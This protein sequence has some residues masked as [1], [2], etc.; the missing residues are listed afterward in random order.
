MPTL[1]DLTNHLIRFRDDRNW[2]QFHTLRNLIVSLHLESGELL[3]LT[4]W[5]TDAQMDASQS[6]P[7]SSEAL[8]DECADVLMYLLMIA[9]HAG[10]DLMAATARK[11]EKN[12]DRYPIGTAYGS[13]KKHAAPTQA[14]IAPDQPDH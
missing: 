14:T 4:Q 12:A 7:Q 13:A 1:Q 2:K 10:F 9:E 6:D 3:E 11:M 8:R 5:K